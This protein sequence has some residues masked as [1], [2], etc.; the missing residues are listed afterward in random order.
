MVARTLEPPRWP[1]EGEPSGRRRHR[2]FLRLRRL[3]HR[4]GHFWSPTAAASS[5]AAPAERSGAPR[6][7]RDARGPQVS[8]TLFGPRASPPAT[9]FQIPRCSVCV[10]P[11]SIDLTAG[12]RSRGYLPHF[13]EAGG[14]SAC[15]VR[16]H[17]SLPAA[18]S[19]RVR[20]RESRPGS[21]RSK[22]RLTPAGA[23]GGSPSLGLPG[24]CRQRSV[25]STASG[26]RSRPGASLPTHVHVPVPPFAGYRLHEIVQGWKSVSSR[27]ANEPCLDVAAASGRS[28]TS[29]G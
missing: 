6:C 7:G 1:P 3:A 22:P 12:V 27:R 19:A 23:S 8:D 25:I 10:P 2:P 24:R 15:C 17:D 18:L 20:A 13:D 26:S 16:L 14:L 29:I 21:K 28:T 11:C 4:T 5:S 9:A